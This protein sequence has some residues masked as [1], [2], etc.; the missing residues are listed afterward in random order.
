[1]TTTCHAAFVRLCVCACL[2]VCVCVCPKA[3]WK[4]SRA[5]TRWKKICDSASG[6]IADPGGWKMIFSSF[7]TQHF[8][9]Q[10]LAFVSFSSP[11]LSARIRKKKNVQLLLVCAASQWRQNI[12]G[13]LAVNNLGADWTGKWTS[14][15]YQGFCQQILNERGPMWAKTGNGKLLGEDTRSL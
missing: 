3:A 9:Q 14:L 7:N 13:S 1:M 2:L 11:S 6:S 4:R 12:S 10:I 15:F 8:H 5:V